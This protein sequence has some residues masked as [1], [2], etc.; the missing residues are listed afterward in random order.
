ML[1]RLRGSEGEAEARG[2]FARALKESPGSPARP[3]V[4]EWYPDVEQPLSTR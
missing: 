3:V 4:R 1:A 2:F